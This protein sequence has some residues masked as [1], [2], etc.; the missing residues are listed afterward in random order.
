MNISIVCVVYN[1][2]DRT[3]LPSD[4]LAQQ[5]GVKATWIFTVSCTDYSALQ[6]ERHLPFCIVLPLPFISKLSQKSKENTAQILF[7]KDI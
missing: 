4:Y 1:A 5:W 6:A 2:S 7:C 3:A